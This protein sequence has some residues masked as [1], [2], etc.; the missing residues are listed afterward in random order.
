MLTAAPCLAA[1]GS[2]GTKWNTTGIV[3][4]AVTP[5]Y[6]TGYGTVKAVFGTQPAPAPG[7][8][9]S[10]QGGAVDF[11]NV[12][13]GS[14]YLYKYAAHLNVYT[15]ASSFIVYAEG[16]AD[17]TGTGSNTGNVLP[18]NQSIY[19]LPSVNGT[20]QTDANTGF[21]SSTPFQKTSQPGSAYNN[22][23]ITYTTTPSPIYVSPIGGTVDLYYDFQLKLPSTA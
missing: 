7:P 19:W 1:G 21:S 23:A 10:Y 14:D 2:V 22:P 6:A 20:S 3:K 11:G 13:Q 8:G 5:N 18:I 12:V 16:S 4:M 17:F 9:A 15:N